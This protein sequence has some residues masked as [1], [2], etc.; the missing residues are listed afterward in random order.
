MAIFPLLVWPLALSG[1][2]SPLVQSAGI[3]GCLAYA[4][5]I[6]MV[7]AWLIVAFIA[8]LGKHKHTE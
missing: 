7:S 6:A 5:A 4:A 8:E 2:D 1:A 3:Y